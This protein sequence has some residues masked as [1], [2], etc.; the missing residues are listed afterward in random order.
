MT[1]TMEKLNRKTYYKPDP[2]IID[3]MRMVYYNC[4]KAV[5]YVKK[6]GIP[7][8]LVDQYIDIFYDFAKDLN[9]CDRC[10]GLEDC[11]KDNPLLCTKVTYTDG[12]VERQLTPCK[13]L[14][15]KMHLKNQF[16]VKDFSD[17]WFSSD[18]K[19]L[20]NNAGRKEAVRRYLDFLKNGSNQ[21]L[22]LTGEQNTGRSF[23]AATI[24]IDAAKKERGPVGFINCAKRFKQ[25]ADMNYRNPELFQKTINAYSTVPVLVLDDFGNEY[26]NEFERDGILFEIL[27]RRA[28]EKLFTIFTS[29]FTIEE[30]ITL[31]STNKAATVRAK[32]IGKIITNNAKEEINL[33]DI[34]IY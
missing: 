17:D 20:N 14:L 24:V 11:Q 31:Y 15:E 10:P 7:D 9:Y 18:L 22:Y 16:I 33:G 23:V 2:A 29:D 30:I 21:W 34:S 1:Q 3:K 4:K 6:L 26:K 19:K 27:S 12:F 8:E 32:Q 13:K 5:A 25:L 28:S